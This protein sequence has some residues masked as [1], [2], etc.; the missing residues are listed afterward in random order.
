MISQVELKRFFNKSF[1]TML[2]IYMG[3]VFIVYVLV[4]LYPPEFNVLP[5]NE[6]VIYENWYGI[7]SQNISSSLLI[8]LLGVLTL[9]TISTLV[10]F[11][12]LYILSIAIYTAYLHSGAMSYAIAVIMVHGLL[13]IIGIVLSYYLSTLSIRMLINRVYKREIFFI[14][15]VKG[16]I[17]LLG[18]MAM[19]FLFASFIEAFATPALLSYLV[20]NVI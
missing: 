5:D 15:D 9:G 10:A 11:Y 13:E 8:I 16:T 14:H 20:E 2:A 18:I 17:R 19:I 3:I 12:N 4:Y 6:L 7:F 1:T